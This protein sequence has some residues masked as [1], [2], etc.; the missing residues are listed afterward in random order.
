MIAGRPVTT[1]TFTAASGADASAPFSGSQGAPPFP[2]E[3]FLRNAPAGLTFPTDLSGGMVVISVEP[4]PDDS[5]APFT[6]EPLLGPIP[7]TAAPFTSYAMSRNAT[8]F[9]TGTATIR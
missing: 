2:G 1:G 6:L 3:D 7:A 5:P 8:P 9:P 4:F